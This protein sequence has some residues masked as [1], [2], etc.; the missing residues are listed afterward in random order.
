MIIV[1][2]YNLAVE[3]VANYY[4]YCIQYTQQTAEPALIFMFWMLATWVPAGLAG[5]I[6]A[7]KCKFEPETSCLRI[8]FV[9]LGWAWL[10]ASAETA[11][12]PKTAVV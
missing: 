8:M 2:L 9:F 1:E 5:Q 10:I 11:L 7:W 12:E 3:F 4:L 6:I